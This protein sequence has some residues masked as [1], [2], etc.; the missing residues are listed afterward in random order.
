MA[1]PERVTLWV[2]KATMAPEEVQLA[3]DLLSGAPGA[4]EHFVHVYHA[5]LYQYSYL[6]CGQPQDAE[7]VSQETLLNVFE[8]LKQL[9]R[10][11]RLTSW[12]FR[13][14]KNACLMK[15]RKSVFAPAREL[16]LDEPVRSRDG[17]SVAP[18]EIP[19]GA[20]LPDAAILQSELRN[21]ID[22][23]IAELP[24]LYR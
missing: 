20:V 23:G 13:I 15:R 6:M 17:S 4:F 8:N 2:G 18:A 7:E 12:V 11:E 24:E 19:D 1:S 10:P 3:R 9:Q 16:S 21:R 5:K 14:A 22:I